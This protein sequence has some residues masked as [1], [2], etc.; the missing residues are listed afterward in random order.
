[1]SPV[2]GY[3]PQTVF[4]E[5]GQPVS[6][7]QYIAQGGAADYSNVKPGSPPTGGSLPPLTATAPSSAPAQ[8][9]ITIFNTKLLELLGKAQGANDNTALTVQREKLQNENLN[10]STK[11]AG[12]LGI[13]N[14]SPGD[15]LN[16]RE[17]AGSL[18]NPE[19][20]SLNDRMQLNNEAVDRFTKT[21]DAAQKLG[22]QY[23]KMIKPSDATIEAIRMQ[24]RAGVLPK[25]DVLAKVQGQLTEDD[26]HAYM[27]AK[28]TGQRKPAGFH[29]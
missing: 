7:D 5:Q 2:S 22:E 4:N 1:L 27:A 13:E 14:L 9:P 18:Y 26:W 16:A 24:L 15:A 19:I 11:P 8:D 23:S 21:L 12:E 3:D 28:G 25:D 10:A 29:R 20:K 17:H 6:H